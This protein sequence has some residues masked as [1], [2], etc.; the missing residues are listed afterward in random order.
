MMLYFISVVILIVHIRTTFYN[1]AALGGVTKLLGYSMN[2]PLCYD[3]S[4]NLTLDRLHIPLTIGACDMSHTIMQ[5][6]NDM[7]GIDIFFL[8]LLVKTQTLVYV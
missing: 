4:I 6:L 3:D 5:T 1:C 8:Q 2:F 7:K